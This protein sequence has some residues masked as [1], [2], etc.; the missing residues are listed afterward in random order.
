MLTLERKSR[1]ALYRLIHAETPKIHEPG[2][3]S[4]HGQDRFVADT[5]FRGKTNGIFVDVGAHDGVTFSNT[6]YLERE[7]AWKGVAVEPAPRVFERLSKARTCIVVKCAVADFDGEV[8]FLELEGYSEMCSGIPSRQHRFHRA[9][10]DREQQVHGGTRR[11]I[12]VPCRKLQTILEEFDIHEID[13]LSLDTEGNEYDILSSL[14]FDVIQ[15]RTISVENN[16]GSRKIQRLLN[17]NGFRLVALAGP[18][19]I[20]SRSQSANQR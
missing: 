7:L 15:I 17:T 14:D 9:R 16:Y 11:T 13:Y 18:D 3:F 2:Y 12:V 1:R 6:C 5:L 8:E 4:Q 10:I 19:E 20:Y